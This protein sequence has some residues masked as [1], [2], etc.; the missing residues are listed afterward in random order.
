MCGRSLSQLQRGIENTLD[1]LQV[2]VA[3][4]KDS[5]S[6]VSAIHDAL[7]HLSDEGRSWTL[8]VDDVNPTTEVTALLKQSLPDHARGAQ[9]ILNTKE[10]DAQALHLLAPEG[11]PQINL[12]TVSPESAKAIFFSAAGQRF[13]NPTDTERQYVDEI[14]DLLHNFPLAVKHAGAYLKRQA[15]VSLF[16]LL[17]ILQQD[18]ARQVRKSSVLWHFIDLS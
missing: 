7:Q 13:A 12:Q 6:R 17:D 16:E 11:T 10:S 15:E 18:K 4:Q 8:V 14:T 2:R 1:I 3:S 9:I 5:S